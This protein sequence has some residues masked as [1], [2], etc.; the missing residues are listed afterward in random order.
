ML[1][2]YGRSSVAA[3]SREEHYA[4]R[5]AVTEDRPYRFASEVFVTLVLCNVR[6]FSHRR[7]QTG[8]TK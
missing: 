8:L 1:V 4:P 6:V 7:T 5:G 3:P 2:L